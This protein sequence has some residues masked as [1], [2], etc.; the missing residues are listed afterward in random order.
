MSEVMTEENVHMLIVSRRQALA[1]QQRRAAWERALPG[2][3]AGFGVATLLLTLAAS[4]L[5]A[6]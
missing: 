5:G 6:G 2:L 3:F 1:A 4:L